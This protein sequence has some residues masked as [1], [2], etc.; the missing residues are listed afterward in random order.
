MAG[1]TSTATVTAVVATR[2]LFSF[3]VLGVF[4]EQLE[5]VLHKTLGV[6]GVT[7]TTDATGPWDVPGSTRILHFTG[8]HKAAEL[9]TASNPPDYFAYVVSD[10]PDHSPSGAGGAR[11]V[12]VH[13]RRRPG[14]AT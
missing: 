10:Q 7:R 8:G 4:G 9:L 14:L 2:P 12:A 5:T 6:P 1:V 13:R 11:E 3:L